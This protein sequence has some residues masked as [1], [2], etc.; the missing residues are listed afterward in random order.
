MI[1]TK[2]SR[3]QASRV[4][5]G[6]LDPISFAGEVNVSQGGFW[7]LFKE[8]IQYVEGEALALITISDDIDFMIDSD[9]CIAESFA[10][11]DKEIAW[12]TEELRFSGAIV[13]SYPHVDIIV[14]RADFC[15]VPLDIEPKVDSA[16]AME[17]EE[18]SGGTSL[19]AYYRKKTRDYR[20]R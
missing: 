9:I 1:Q 10:S 4:I 18:L 14:E 19:Q 7:K 12:L 6:E 5:N 15:S 16:S 20:R 13:T 2:K 3:V 17:V 11:T 8:K